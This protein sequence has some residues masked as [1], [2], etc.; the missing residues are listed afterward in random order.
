MVVF[1][2]LPPA[3]GYQPHPA[4]QPLFA[5][6]RPAG[7]LRPYP[8]HCP[9][10]AVFSEFR[11]PVPA[12]CACA[13]R[14]P[15][16]ARHHPFFSRPQ[17]H[18]PRRRAAADYRHRHDGFFGTELYHGGH[19]HRQGLY[20]AACPAGACFSAGR[21]VYRPRHAAHGPKAPRRYAPGDA[22][23]G[24]RETEK[25]GQGEGKRETPPRPAPALYGLPARL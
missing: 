18:S 22:G 3:A 20:G 1:V 7:S 4:R 15:D 11:D 21:A 10:R 5:D 14:R 16:R 19:F 13:R 2:V 12:G 6:G 8:R 25:A 24:R 9:A 23:G 17:P